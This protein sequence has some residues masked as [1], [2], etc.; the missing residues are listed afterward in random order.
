MRI[1]VEA[2]R[3]LLPRA[4]DAGESSGAQVTIMSP[5]ALSS[6]SL[7]C[8]CVALCTSP[9]PATVCRLLSAT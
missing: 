9:I 7:C 3:Q 8:F 1:A 4:R 6:S 2:M 5:D